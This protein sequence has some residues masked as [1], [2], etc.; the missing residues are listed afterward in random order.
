M[1]ENGGASDREVRRSGRLAVQRSWKKQGAG[2]PGA[3]VGCVRGK[4][5]LK[6]VAWL[7][8]VGGDGAARQR[9]GPG[10]KGARPPEGRRR[11][12]SG[13]HKRR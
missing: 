3:L 2:L 9:V 13:R 10:S 1:P 5:E 7:A 8:L 6:L 4:G 12:S 11:A